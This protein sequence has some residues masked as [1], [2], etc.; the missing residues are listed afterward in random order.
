MVQPV[1]KCGN[2]F[3]TPTPLGED[4]AP[5]VPILLVQGNQQGAHF[6]K[7]AKGHVRLRPASQVPGPIPQRPGQR[8]QSFLGSGHS[9][10]RRFTR[11]WEEPFSNHYSERVEAWYLNWNTAGAG[12]LRLMCCIWN[13]EE[14]TCDHLSRT[15][16]FAAV[17]I[18][19]KVGE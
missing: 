4:L 12:Y 3:Q 17:L 16:N 18:T 1:G 2:V 7:L 15:A 9:Y 10:W 11:A 19:D 13:S 6:G 8:L 14:S 5:P